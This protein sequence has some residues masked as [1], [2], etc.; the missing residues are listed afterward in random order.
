MTD[1]IMYL[2]PQ[3]LPSCLYF[4]LFLKHFTYT[5]CLVMSLFKGLG[6]TALMMQ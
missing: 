1:G 2:S 5:L 6:I 3:G 4:V